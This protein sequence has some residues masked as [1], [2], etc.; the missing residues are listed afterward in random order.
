MKR[1][2]L[3]FILFF[4][5]F[6]ASAHAQQVT[7]SLHGPDK[8]NTDFN[9]YVA[10]SSMDGFSVA[11]FTVLYNPN[12]LEFKGVSGGNFSTITPQKSGNLVLINVPDVNGVDGS[13]SIATLSFGPKV[14]GTSYI[15]LSTIQIVNNL[16]NKA[17]VSFLGKHSVEI[18]SGGSSVPAY[19]NPFAG[20]SATPMPEPEEEEETQLSDEEIFEAIESGVDIQDLVPAPEPYFVIEDGETVFGGDDI[21]EEQSTGQQDQA[22]QSGGSQA[23]SSG[24]SDAATGDFTESGSGEGSE[25]KPAGSGEKKDSKDDSKEGGAKGF[26]L[27]LVIGSLLVLGL[28]GGGGFFVWKKVQSEGGTPASAPSGPSRAPSRAP[29]KAAPAQAAAKPQYTD[30]QVEQ[31]LLQNYTPE[32][33][34]AYQMM[35]T[36][37]KAQYIVQYR[38]Q[39][40]QQG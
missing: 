38:A 34:E 24:A 6:T 23:G 5:I 7:V 16:A 11:S 9:V 18:L 39:L 27:G 3:A 1:I 20:S 30:Q 31:M 12:S 28:L 10:L 40:A 33:Q 32:Q 21:T 29:A 37:Q 14:L 22:P 17:Q 8:V 35:S 36:E 2:F 25:G 26:P 13:G 15:T 4:L 19:T